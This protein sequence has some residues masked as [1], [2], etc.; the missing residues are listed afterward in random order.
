MQRQNDKTEVSRV[1]ILATRTPAA[2]TIME[3]VVA[4]SIMAIVFATILPLF[5]NIQNSWDSKQ[6]TA[7]AIQNGRVLIDHLNHNFA[8]AVKITAVS[9][10]ST[11]NGYIEFEDNDGGNLRYSIENNYAQFGPV[12]NLSDLAG[13]VSQLQFTCYDANNFVT[14][15]TEANDIRFIEV[16]T[17]LTNSA[18]PGQDK[19]FSTSVYL[20]A[21]ADI[22]GEGITPKTA[23]EFNIF[24]G[25]NPALAQIETGRYLCAYKGWD[26]SGRAVVLTVNTTTWEITSGIT[27]NYA[28]VGKTPALTQIDDDN[29]LCAYE[30]GGS[31]GWAVILTV[32]PVTWTVSEGTAFEYDGSKGK[33]PAL[34]QIDST[35]YLCAYTGNRDDGWAAVLKVD[36]GTGTIT[37]ESSF[38]FDN[39]D[40]GTPA[41]S[42]IDDT[43]YLCAYKGRRSDGWATVLTVNTGTWA[44]TK[45]TPF[46][47]DTRDGKTPALAK[48]D[49]THYLCA[50]NGRD[51]DGWA[52]VLTV[53]TGTWTI[54]KETPFEY[55]TQTGKTPVLAQMDDSSFV[56]AYTGPGDD[57]WAVVLA[58]NLITWTIS[59]QTP[60]EYDSSTGKV[61]ALK[62]ID[63]KRCLCPY[64]GKRD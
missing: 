40:G 4:F 31:D 38:E 25:K 54:T 32:N 8:K 19:T 10:S 59:K 37:K 18:A 30:G 29:Y 16:E 43:H 56:C 36:T 58:V 17:T 35:H 53:N 62:K 27:L 33:T 9:D 34:A 41:L 63:D 20:R 13:P 45:E 21:N 6:G 51:N 2:L 60:V 48:I 7:E 39:Q 47:F 28:S 12:G 26:G 3:M 1:A 52:T 50:Y 61:P 23:F 64:Q 49:D 42:K 44:I 5:R 24:E 22:Y 55:D 57:G 11:T 14:P 46:E 15:I